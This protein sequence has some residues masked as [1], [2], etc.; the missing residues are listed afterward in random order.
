MTDSN[1]G[2]GHIP[3]VTPVTH[4]DDEGCWEVL[5]RLEFGRIAYR[6]GTHLDIA[7]INYAVHQDQ[8]VFRTATGSKLSGILGDGE[9]VFEV[10]E[11]TDRHAVSVVVRALAKEM[12]RD[13]A[14][15]VDQ[16]RLRPWVPTVKEYVVV[17]EPQRITGRWFDIS[18]PWTSM[19]PQP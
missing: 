4:L 5:R 6:L 15:W 17:L 3:T 13:K 11:V 7:P 1:A 8:I 14:R 2:A 19:R 10:D 9:V 16:M 12:D 18:R